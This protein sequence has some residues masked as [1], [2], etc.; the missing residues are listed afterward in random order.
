[1]LTKI[2]ELLF[3]KK[4]LYKCHFWRG[5]RREGY[6]SATEHRICSRKDDISDTCRTICELLNRIDGSQ[7]LR[8]G[9]HYWIDDFVPFG[10]WR[11][12]DQ[13]GKAVYEYSGYMN[14]DDIIPESDG[15]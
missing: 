12:V 13:V 11:K 2:K 9:W 8:N 6:L 7:D 5:L 10:T 14:F 15:E 1:M 3:G 4:C